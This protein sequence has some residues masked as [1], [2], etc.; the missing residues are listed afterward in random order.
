[1]HPHAN[2]PVVAAGAPLNGARGAV[3]MIHGR[4]ASPRDILSLV[5]T[6]DVPDIAYIAPAAANHTWYPL[7][8]LAETSKNEPYLSSALTR[9]EEV[10]AGIVE[11]GIDMKRVVWLG[12]S[13]GACLASEFVVRH[14]NRY[15]G[16]VAFSG[17][18]IGPAGT[19]WNFPGSLDTTPVFLGCSDVDAHV[20]KARVDETAVVLER[21]GAAVTKRIYAGMGHLI[22]D[23]EIE[24]AR[25]MIKNAIER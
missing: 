19:S 8:F 6:L 7:T 5:P 24:F 2:Q 15:G 18:L 3:I 23:E 10:L 21:M 4:N 13:Q 20:P 12:F 16:L 17:G 25:R 9:L 1:M 14:A 22:N 11:R